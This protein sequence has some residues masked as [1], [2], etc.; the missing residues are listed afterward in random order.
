M[1]FPA[2]TL[3]C[4]TDYNEEQPRHYVGILIRTNA[5]R[6]TYSVISEGIN[7]EWFCFMCKVLS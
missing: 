2:G 1:D 7:K 6:G 3:V 5:M 4:Y